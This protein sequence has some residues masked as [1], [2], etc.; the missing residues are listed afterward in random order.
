[1]TDTLDPSTDLTRETVL[2]PGDIVRFDQPIGGE[3]L[4]DN[5][6]YTHGIVVEIVQR[7]TDRTRDGAPKV[8]GVAKYTPDE[9][10]APAGGR[11]DLESGKHTGIPGIADCLADE[12]ILLYKTGRETGYSPHNEHVM[13]LIDHYAADDA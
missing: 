4:S 3:S 10:T 2:E 9:E 6:E 12:L 1:M 5:T 8:L 7:Y 13:D 11:L